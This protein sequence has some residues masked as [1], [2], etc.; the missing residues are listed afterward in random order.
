MTASVR[1]ICVSTD[2]GAAVNVGGPTEV[3]R[4]TF[5]LP[6]TPELSAWL[7]S[8]VGTYESRWIE[9]VEFIASAIHKQE[10]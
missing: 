3:K 5:D 10:D 2:H 6:C 8:K 7:E 9:G 1:I 4:K